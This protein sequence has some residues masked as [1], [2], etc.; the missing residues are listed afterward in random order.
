MF[1]LRK[2]ATRARAVVLASVAALV[3]GMSLTL[4]VTGAAAASTPKLTVTPISATK[5][6]VTGQYPHKS[7]GKVTALYLMVCENPG[8][9]RPGSDHCAVDWSGTNSSL[10]VAPKDA[11]AR[12]KA[13]YGDV[14]KTVG[15]VKNGVW[16]FTVDVT[17]PKSFKIGS[18]T[19]KCGTTNKTCGIGTRLSASVS[20]TSKTAD[21]FVFGS[22]KSAKITVSAKGITAKAAGTAKVT[23]ATTAVSKPT[24]KVTLKVAGK[25]V[26][27]TLKA[28]AKGK[29]SLK[30]PKLKK[31][32]YKA[33]VTFTPS[34]TNKYAT[35]KST[36]TTTIT[37]K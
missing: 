11:D 4:G 31:G 25:T 8:K 17:V 28:S 37:V 27:K 19:V 10:V 35:K 5:V 18:R 1:T 15:A 32:S 14:L 34:G 7:G 23:V 16:T 26:T 2:S 24:G 20:V 9:D 22:Q 12:T 30:L 13:L 33:T 36:K 29:V 6:R 3:A 21:K